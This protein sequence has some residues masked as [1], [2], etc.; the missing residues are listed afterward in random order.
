[1]AE[2]TPARSTPTDR[3]VPS[4]IQAAWETH[5]SAAVGHPNRDSFDWLNLHFGKVDQESRE[6]FVKLVL[7]GLVW[8]TVQAFKALVE[9]NY[10]WISQ[11]QRSDLIVF[12]YRLDDSDRASAQAALD[13][14]TMEEPER[15][16][17]ELTKGVR[18]LGEAL[19][20]PK[21]VGNAMTLE[22]YVQLVFTIRS[23]H[24]SRQTRKG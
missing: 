16:L 24:Q 15:F 6:L 18:G 17:F 19:A 2:T 5:F 8:D 20:D 14:Q 1:M 13:G 22:E 12:A 4:P 21:R 23:I 3:D 7:N 10:A 11:R 9:V